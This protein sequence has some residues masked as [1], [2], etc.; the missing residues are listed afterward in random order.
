MFSYVSNWIMLP[1]DD[2][3]ESLYWMSFLV[4][5]I[6]LETGI[7]LS[8]NMK[9]YHQDNFHLC[10]KPK[11]NYTPG[12]VP[13][14][15]TFS[16]FSSL[17]EETQFWVLHKGNVCEHLCHQDTCCLKQSIKKRTQICTIWR[18]QPWTKSFYIS[19]INN[20]NIKSS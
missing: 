7:K 15:Q 3:L 10:W 16:V 4:L 18:K 6:M 9:T 5:S 1:H 12:S 14:H 11:L 2:T 17:I 20:K 19:L 8:P 13:S